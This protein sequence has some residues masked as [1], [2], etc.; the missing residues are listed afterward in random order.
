MMRRMTTDL[1]PLRLLHTSDWHLGQ[2]LHGLPRD[3][4]HRA[5]LTWLLDTLDA[6]SIDALLITGD[7]FDSQNPPVSAQRRLYDF[8]AEAKRRRPALDIVIIGGNHDS[9]TRLEAPDAIL[10]PFDVTVVGSL[11]RDPA[12]ALVTVTDAQGRPRA[13][14]CA[15]PFI[16]M[17]DLPPRKEVEDGP[18]PLVEGVRDVYARFIEAARQA[19]QGL[20]LV[21]TGHCYMSGS[22]VSEMSERRVLGGNQHALPAD[23]FPEDCHYVAL[24][25]LHKPQR[26]AGRDAM[27]YAGSPFPLSVTEKDYKHQVMLVEITDAAFPAAVTGLPVPRAIDYLRVPATGADTPDAVLKALAALPD[28]PDPGRDRRPYLEVVVRLESPSPSLRHD[29]EQIL[30][31]KPV[32][33]CRLAVEYAGTGQALAAMVDTPDLAGLDPEDVFAR[34]WTRSY[35]GEPDAAHRRAFH[36]LMET[37]Q[38]DAPET[39]AAEE[40]A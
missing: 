11:P 26:V 8:L 36:E 13:M 31:E 23:V 10:R 22:A 17:A 32:R 2:D 1:A 34:A 29:V 9:A 18:D 27:R 12:D 25:H 20:P 4:E 30:A 33:L 7:V 24:G 21:V 3:A 15:V 5:F 16:R 19:A 14:V 39:A 38:G 40:T 6:Q 37:V 28:A 35:E